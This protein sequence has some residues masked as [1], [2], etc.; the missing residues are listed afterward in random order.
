MKSLDKSGWFSFYHMFTYS[1]IFHS[2]FF[3]T[4]IFILHLSIYSIGYSILFIYTS[5]FLM[6][7]PLFFLHIVFIHLLIYPL[8]SK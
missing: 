5:I 6:Y 7:L 4:L 2:L 8:F 1:F 3:D